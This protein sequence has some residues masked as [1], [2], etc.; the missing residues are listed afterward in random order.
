VI[1]H[2]PP[3]PLIIV[4]LHAVNRPY[5]YALPNNDSPDGILAPNL[6]VRVDSVCT[7]R[8]LNPEHVQAVR[9]YFTHK[10]TVVRR[11]L[12]TDK[13]TLVDAILKIEE[14]FDQATW[15][16]ASAVLF[17]PSAP[18]ALVIDDAFQ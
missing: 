1:D 18:H 10:I 7:K 8:S 3:C 15:V 9:H 4:I 17:E 13:S 2:G 5:N 11:P 6:K 14:E 16:C 12:G